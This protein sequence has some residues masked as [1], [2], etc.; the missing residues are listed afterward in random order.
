MTFWSLTTE[1][2]IITVQSQSEPSTSFNL[3]PEEDQE[4]NLV[5]PH[6]PTD[7]KQDVENSGNTT[8]DGKKKR[9]KN[10]FETFSTEAE[11]RIEKVKHSLNLEKELGEMR[12]QQEQLKIEL[13]KQQLETA[14][15]EEIFLKEKRQ[16]ELSVLKS[17][18]I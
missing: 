3:G 15:N 11:V 12:K 9:Q 10:K 14:V 18:I 13:L 16:L 1:K 17:K 7:K 6:L 5:I 4:I 8:M 2:K